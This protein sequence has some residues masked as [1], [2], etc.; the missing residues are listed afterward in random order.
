VQF[1]ASGIPSFLRDS[2]LPPPPGE[3]VSLTKRFAAG[4]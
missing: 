3:K 4:D 1:G 2:I